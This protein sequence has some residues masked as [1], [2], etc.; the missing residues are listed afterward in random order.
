[1]GVADTNVVV[2]EVNKR[3]HP[4]KVFAERRQITYAPPER[5]R[6]GLDLAIWP[7]CAVLTTTVP[8]I[9][10]AAAARLSRGAIFDRWFSS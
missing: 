1:M 10:R 5:A 7:G 8:P 3:K 2:Q 9:G 6:E 4:L